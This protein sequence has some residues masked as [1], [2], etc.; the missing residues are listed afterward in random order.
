MVKLIIYTQCMMT[1]I[2]IYKIK[3]L[4]II[5][6]IVEKRVVENKMMSVVLFDDKPHTSHLFRKTDRQTDR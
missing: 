2:N 1:L 6:V 5:N 4:E 3:Y